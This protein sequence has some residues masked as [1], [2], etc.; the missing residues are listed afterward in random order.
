MPKFVLNVDV[1]VEAVD[2]EAATA[3]LDEVLGWGV[4]KGIVVD[5]F[6]ND[7]WEAEED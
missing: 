5:S 4:D 2:C 7:G 1:T 6:F 3:A